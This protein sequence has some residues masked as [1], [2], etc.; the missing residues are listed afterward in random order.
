MNDPVYCYPPDHTIL[1]NKLGIRDPAELDVT[2]REYSTF[3]IGQGCPVGD[4][5]LDHLRAI[6]AHIFQD[7]YDWAGGLRMVEI[8]KGGSQFMPRQFIET[9]MADVHR[10]VVS[11]NYLQGLNS[12]DFAERAGE[13][14]GDINHIHPFREGNGRTQL[15]YLRQLS[16]QAG[17]PI[18]LRKLAPGAW[19]RA[20]IEANRGEYQEMRAS[21]ITALEHRHESKSPHISKEDYAARFRQAQQVTEMQANSKKH[22]I[23]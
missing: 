21:I 12:D 10:R 16:Y 22:K 9:G 15:Q 11:E 7:V 14:I 4:F 23:E 8:S 20:S 18:D 5:D 13:I 2:E 19:I 1:R 3:R 6:H 17:H